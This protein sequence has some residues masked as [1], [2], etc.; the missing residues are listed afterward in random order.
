MRVIGGSA[1]GRILRQPRGTKI[2]PTS[3]R[4]KEA[5]FNILAGKIED[6]IVLDLFAGTGA[7]GIEALSR[8]ASRA[9]FVDRQRDSII[10][11]RRNLLLTGLLPSAELYRQDAG[12]ALSLFQRQGRSFDLVFIDP[13]YGE[14]MTL[15]ILRKLAQSGVLSS[16]GV[17]AVEHSRKEDLPGRIAN[18]QLWRQR[19]YGD[20]VL[21]FYSREEESNPL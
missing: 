11:V 19:R 12:A 9:V 21:T 20:T 17:V 6:A 16:G 18:L 10:L 14:G 4:V 3:D 5:L 7:L 8:G 13:P 1:R 2:R 15:S